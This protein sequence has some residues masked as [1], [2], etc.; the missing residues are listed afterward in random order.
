MTTVQEHQL[1]VEQHL[2]GVRL[3]ITFKEYILQRDVVSRNLLLDLCIQWLQCEGHITQSA[4]VN[5]VLE[6]FQ[7]FHTLHY[8]FSGEERKEQ[9][10]KPEIWNEFMTQHTK[11]FSFQKLAEFL[12]HGKV[13]PSENLM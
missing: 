5:G 12:L 4:E 8:T 2:R 10:T 3:G 11:C 9:I 13:L 6:W 1:A 7:D